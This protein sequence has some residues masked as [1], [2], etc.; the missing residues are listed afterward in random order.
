MADTLTL[1]Q[2]RALWWSKQ[3]FGGGPGSLA[4]LIGNSGW[5]RTLGGADVYLAA[6]ARKP[7]MRRAELDAVV[8]N[9]DLRIVPAVRGC[10][11]LVPPAVVSNLMALNAEPWRKDTERDLAK[12]GSS[13]KIV[14]DVAKRVLDALATQLTTD[15][16]R[17]AL[18]DGAIPSFGDPGKK[19]G[20]SSPLPLALRMLEFD[21]RIE[22]TLEGG[23]LDSDRYHWRKT[24]VSDAA[25]DSGGALA[26]V[27]GAFLDFAGP[28]TLAHI[29]AWSKRPQRDL[30]PVLDHLGAKPVTIDGLGE[31]WARHGD[32]GAAMRAPEPRGFAL[33]AFEDNYLVNHGGLAAVTE[34]RHHEISIDIWGGSKPEAITTANHVLS[35]TIVLDGFVVGM[36]EVDPRANRA[37]WYTFDPAPKP[38][39]AKLDELTGD[40]AR[41]LLDEIGHACAFTL[42]TM[43]L[44]QERADRI[45][46]LRSG[47][48]PK[49]APV[50]QAKPAKPVAAP[51]VAKPAAA[52][53]AAAKPAAAKP[54]AAK[55]AAAKLAAAKPAAAAARPAAAKPAAKP[56]PKF[57][58]P[59]SGKPAKKSAPT[60]KR[61]R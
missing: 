48:S 60:K 44:V 54:A 57:A 19:I 49:L 18:P 10:I 2:A 46:G 21:G 27:V 16:L 55:P 40:A 56:K 39:A 13:M 12:L 61:K 20:M 31:A 8:A 24:R 17:A 35:R 50:K 9:G 59:R 36:W 33:L 45:S 42:D 29:A 53:L 25:R 52:K 7:G 51:P 41:F 58:K 22:R 26:A 34:P 47:K 38:L 4:S 43:E 6:R 23:R 3:A 15:G 32:V 11:Y 28:C 1:A 37:V 30:R 14:E 5:L